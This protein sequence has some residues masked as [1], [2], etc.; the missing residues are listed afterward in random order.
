MR[1]VSESSS[2]TGVILNVPSREVSKI[3]SPF[4][5]LERYVL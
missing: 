4:R 3:D 5:A 2:V 1:V